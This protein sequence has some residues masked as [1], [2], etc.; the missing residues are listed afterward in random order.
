MEN[1]KDLIIEYE[2]GAAFIVHK[3][4]LFGVVDIEGKQVADLVAFNRSNKK[5]KLSTAATI[6]NNASIFLRQGNCIFSNLYHAML[7]VVE[8]TVGRHDLLY[9][10]CSPDM[11][12]YQ[13]GITESHR[14]CL[15]NLA[16]AL[17]SHSIRIEEIPGPVNIFMNTRVSEDGTIQV[18]EPLSKAGDH[19]T[20]KAEMDIIVAVSACPVRE[21]KC[22]AFSCKPIK[23]VLE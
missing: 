14:S 19:I 7:T 17:R 5:E 16:A 20:F 6:D 4:D 10:A 15:E 21:S 22:N 3:G 18:E 8:D 2:T 9:P 13:Y 23:I 11:Y 12:R 1:K